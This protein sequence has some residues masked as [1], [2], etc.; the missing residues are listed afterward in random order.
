[1]VKN[2]LHHHCSSNPLTCPLGLNYR[3]HEV[4]SVPRLGNSKI[5]FDPAFLRVIKR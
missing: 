1:M 4:C 3:N 5:L 2:I